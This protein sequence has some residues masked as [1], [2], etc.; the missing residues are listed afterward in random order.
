L[1]IPVE[2]RPGTRLSSG[3]LAYAFSPDGEPAT[4]AVV[5]LVVVGQVY[6]PRPWPAKPAPSSASPR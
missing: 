2:H 4:G 1:P 5:Y 6:G 3:D